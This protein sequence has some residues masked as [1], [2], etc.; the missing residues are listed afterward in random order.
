MWAMGM[1]RRAWQA[2]GMGQW[3]R[4]TYELYG[5]PIV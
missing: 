3:G 5:K 4:S 2:D 1:S